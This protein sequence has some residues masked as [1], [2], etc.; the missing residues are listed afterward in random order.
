MPFQLTILEPGGLIDQTARIARGQHAGF[1]FALMSG[2]RDRLDVTFEILAGDSYAPT[3]GTLLRY[4]AIDGV[5]H[6]AFSLYPEGTGFVH[7]VTIQGHA[8]IYVEQAADG[9]AEIAAGLAQQVNQAPIDPNAT[10]SSSSN[11]LTLHD[12]LIDG[13]PVTVSVDGSA[14]KI[15]SQRKEC[16]FAGT[17]DE[18]EAT[19]YSNEG[20]HSTKFA[21]VS[22]ESLFDN[23]IP[24]AQA[25]LDKT[26]AEIF[27]A[28]IAPVLIA[29]PLQTL[30][31]GPIEGGVV[32]PV[33]EIDGGTTIKDYL[34]RL[35]T[36]QTD[37]G[38]TNW[39]WGIDLTT[40]LPTVFF[41]P[42]FPATVTI[43]GAPQ[44]ILWE[45][46]SLAQNRS[47]FRDR[48][49]V[50]VSFDAFTPSSICLTEKEENYPTYL[51]PFLPAQ[52]VAARITRAKVAEGTAELATLP[53]PGD[54]I[55]VGN[56]TYVFVTAASLDNRI[57]WQIVLGLTADAC[58][59]NIVDAINA[60]PET[61]GAAFS[62]PTWENDL[63]NAEL[64]GTGIKLRSKRAG[65]IGN[66]CKLDSGATGLTFSVDHLEGGKNA[67]A[68]VSDIALSLA[69][70]VA[71][72]N[73]STQTTLLSLAGSREVTVV[74]PKTPATPSVD[75]PSSDIPRG[76]DTGATADEY[77][78]TVAPA[79]TELVVGTAYWFQ[80]S[81]TN[82]A[83]PTLA[84]NG[85]P[86]EP[87]KKFDYTTFGVVTDLDP[88]DIVSGRWIQVVWDGAIFLM[89]QSATA[90][91]FVSGV[92]ESENP[93]NY[94][95]TLSPPITAYVNGAVYWVKVL[96]TN[97]VL[98]A[99]LSFDGLTAEV[100]AFK[101]SNGGTPVVN[102]NDIQAGQWVE[103]MWIRS[104]WLMVANFL[105]ST[106]S[107]SGG[108][109]GGGSSSGAATSGDPVP[110]GWLLEVQY[111]RSGADIITVEDSALVAARA[112]IE[113]GTGWYQ[114]VLSATNI[115]DGPSGYQLAV[116]TLAQY[117]TLPY[118]LR[119]ESYRNFINPGDFLAFAITVP[120][121]AAA[122]LNG[123]TWTVQE[124][125]GTYVPGLDTVGNY[126]MR[127]TIVAISGSIIT[128]TQTYIDFW[129]QLANVGKGPGTP[130]KPVIQPPPLD[131]LVFEIYNATIAADVAPHTPLPQSYTVLQVVITPKISPGVADT[132]AV[133]YS[134][135]VAL[136]PVI[137]PVGAPVDEPIIVDPKDWFAP[138]PVVIRE[139]TIQT[140][141]I[142]GGDGAIDYRGVFTVRL[143]VLLTAV[144]VEDDE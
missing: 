55:R 80:A 4:Y 30:A 61:A 127:H 35:V 20:G 23:V 136:F 36:I 144:A 115:K 1:S 90:V 85:L 29:A 79:I 32:V 132:T 64:D 121:G 116:K 11:V 137:I 19:W 28:L 111:R 3:I 2:E 91:T 73:T 142:T 9:G 57:Q 107:E 75:S 60:N 50:R 62:F 140:M 16:V 100:I 42:P 139:G 117:S 56:I 83:P 22:L 15:L 13:S 133:I 118:T 66:E 134:E 49:G 38:G 7:N 24:R 92:D 130:P 52:I 98:P 96:T 63:A 53:Q 126:T 108:G 27:T 120:L 31:I 45:S 86:A 48:Q 41:R 72:A 17:I 12:R 34:D 135:G 47:D 110:T 87:I 37:Q 141:D 106:G 59:S 129:R 99:L 84:L 58:A 82:T 10:A 81:K 88:G 128:R 131:V 67:P 113:H 21:C 68:S 26:T 33:F 6:V 8:Y 125:Q 105:P 112:A 65:L 101:A 39:A 76:P 69:T 70:T 119:F 93:G 104:S 123:M 74:S 143:D 89:V 25:F 40:I 54:T 102:A 46:L 138:Q 78:V 43:T 122:L 71:D 94:A 51:L 14:D 97:A 18:P 109:G 95:A 5:R 77:V 44:E 103:V 124:V 114:K